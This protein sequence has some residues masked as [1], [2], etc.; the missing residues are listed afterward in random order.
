[1]KTPNFIITLLKKFNFKIYYLDNKF[2]DKIVKYNLLYPSLRLKF[3]EKD[4]PTF[5]EHNSQRR[6]PAGL[7]Y[8]SFDLPSVSSLRR[9]MSGL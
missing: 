9:G 3:T 2:N 1:M 6:L 5:K 4:S 7:P 8:N